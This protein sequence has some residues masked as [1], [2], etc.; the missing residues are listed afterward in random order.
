MASVGE[1]PILFLMF[2]FFALSSQILIKQAGG[3][4]PTL[5]F[6]FENKA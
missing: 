4:L 3:F 6:S 2:T 1:Q 5:V